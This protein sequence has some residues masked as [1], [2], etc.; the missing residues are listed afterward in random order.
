MDIFLF[1][2]RVI[3]HKEFKDSQRKTILFFDEKLWVEEKK[4][5][6]YTEEGEIFH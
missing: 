4:E 5:I 3:W 2:R 6:R 1:E